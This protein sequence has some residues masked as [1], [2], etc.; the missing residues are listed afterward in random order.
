MPPPR[1]H[2]INLGVMKSLIYYRRDKSV[3]LFW[4]LQKIAG[5]I[6]IVNTKFI[7]FNKFI[8]KDNNKIDDKQYKNTCK[9]MRYKEINL[10]LGDETAFFELNIS[11]DLIREQ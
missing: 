11:S 6:Y 4:T 10:L 3:F 1:G 5:I 2:K 9:T 7:N 8:S